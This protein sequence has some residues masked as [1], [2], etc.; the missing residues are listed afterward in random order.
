MDEVDIGFLVVGHTHCSIDQYFST[1]SGFIKKKVDFVPTPDAMRYLLTVC[2]HDERRRPDERFV[3][4]LKVVKFFLRI[5]SAPLIHNNRD[6]KLFFFIQGGVG[7]Q[8]MVGATSK[9]R[10]KVHV[11]AASLQDIYSVEESLFAVYALLRRTVAAAEASRV[12]DPYSAW[13]H[14]QR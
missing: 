3:S 11:R 6:L 4:H 7:L 13:G 2:H 5:C 14:S 12:R 9:Y 8:V 1:V 10:Y